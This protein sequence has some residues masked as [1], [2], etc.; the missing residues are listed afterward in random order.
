MKKL[1]NLIPQLT[2]TLLTPF[3][4]SIISPFLRSWFLSLNQ[5]KCFFF[6]KIILA[7]TYC[8]LVMRSLSEYNFFAHSWIR[9]KINNLFPY[10][11]HF[12]PKCK[13]LF[14][15]TISLHSCAFADFR[16]IHALETFTIKPKQE[17]KKKKKNILKFIVFQCFLAHTLDL[18][19]VVVVIEKY[20]KFANLM[21]HADI[22]NWQSHFKCRV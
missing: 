22:L 13:F 17:L 4:F 10:E 15:H 12:W 7:V 1:Q 16:S 3:N 21:L 5:F 2:L 8:K 18:M 14:I 20:K 11:F 9:I 19:L 6:R